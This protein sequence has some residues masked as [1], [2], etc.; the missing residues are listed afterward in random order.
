MNYGE[1][2]RGAALL[3]TGQAVEKAAGA[4]EFGEEFFFGAELAGV[5]DERAAGATRGMFNVE[6]FV[7]KDVFD[8]EL[9]N[10]RM[11]H[12]AI[13][14]DLVGAG[15]VTAE[16][17]APAAGAPTEMGSSER[18]AEKFPVERFEHT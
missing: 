14:K 9:R 15:I 7:I 17:A 11:I 2:V 1:G 3:G 4:V 8:D 5:G 16:L 6:H 13:E 18:T 10:K 12:A